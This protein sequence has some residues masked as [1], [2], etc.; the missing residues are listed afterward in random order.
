[1]ILLRNDSCTI[2]VLSSSHYWIQ[3]LSKVLNYLGIVSLS[4]VIKVMDE[5]RA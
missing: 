2:F 4:S 5:T 1:M 3:F